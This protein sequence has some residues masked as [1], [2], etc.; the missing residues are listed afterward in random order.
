MSMECPPNAGY[1]DALVWEIEHNTLH[2]GKEMK[3]I[4]VQG[5]AS[6]VVRPAAHQGPIRD[7]SST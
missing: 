5:M 1:F 6:T 4:A 7:W 2:L 3:R